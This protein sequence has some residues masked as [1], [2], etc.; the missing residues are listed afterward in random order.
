MLFTP[1][2]LE[3][4][5]YWANKLAGDIEK[6]TIVLGRQQR[7]HAGPGE[8]RESMIINFPGNLCDRLVKLSKGSDLSLY[9]LLMTALKVLIFHCINREDIIVI[10]PVY[11]SR[12]SD[13]TM[14]SCVALRDRV[15]D[16]LTFRELLL[17]V[18][19]ATLQAYE[20][21]DYPFDSL[22]ENVLD[23]TWNNDHISD[24]ACVSSNIHDHETIE[25]LAQKLVFSFTRDAGRLSG[26]IIFEP[27]FYQEIYIEGMAGYFTRILEQAAGDI[28]IKIS[29]ISLLSAQERQQLLVEFNDNRSGYPGNKTILRLF[30]EQVEK[31][32]DHTALVYESQ[33]VTFAE[34][35]KRSD[36]LARHLI[37]KGAA[38]GSITG[39]MVEPCLEMLIGIV[40]ILKAGGIFVPIEPESPKERIS[41]VLKDSGAQVLLTQR[42]LAETLKTDLHTEI[43]I[44]DDRAVYAGETCKL[45]G[46]TQPGDPVYVIYTSGTSGRPKGVLISN[47]N[48]VNYIYWFA[49]SIRL[50]A[51]DRAILTSSFAFD[52]LYTQLFASLLWGCELHIIP[53][54]TFLFAGRLIHYLRDHEITYIKVTPS[55][56]NLI[57]NNPDFSTEMLCR[58]RFIMIGGEEINVKDVEKAH[59]LCPHVRMMNHYGPTETTIGS[60]ARFIDF[61]RFQEYKSVPTIGKPLQ[62]TNVYILDKNFN[63]VP[64]GVSGELFIGGDGVGMGYLNN[65]ELTAGKFVTCSHL[66]EENER[67]YATGDLARWEPDGNIECLGRVDD[68]VK[69]RGYRVEPGEIEN[70][71]LRHGDVK[72][73]LVLPVEKGNGEKYLC[74]YVVAETD[75]DGSQ[76][77]EFLARDLPRYMIPSYFVPLDRMPLTKH[78]KINRQA[79]PVP[80]A[81][82]EGTAGYTAPEDEVEDK[83]A[84]AWAEVLGVKKE[85]IG[86]GLNFFQVGGHSLNAIIL[87]SM[88]HKLFNVEVPLVEL[89]RDPTIKGLAAYIKGASVNRYTAVEPA[90]IKEYYP[91]SSAQK[92][93]YVLQEMDSESTVYNLPLIVWLEGPLNRT[94]F[95]RAFRK[96]IERHDNF[97]TSFNMVDG[98]PIQKI[99]KEVEFGIGYHRLEDEPFT[100]GGAGD[101]RTDKIVRDFVRPFSLEHAPLLR[102]ELVNAAEKK[103]LLMVDMHHIISDGVSN[104][105]LKKEFLQLYA[106]EELSGLRLQYKDFSEWQ[107]NLIECG[108]LEKQK[109]HWLKIFEEEVPVL[110]MPTDYDR[111]ESLSF[112]GSSFNFEIAE[113]LTA[114]TRELALNMGVTLNILLMAV[115]NILLAKYT[116]QEDIVVGTIT[117]GRPHIDL[118]KIIGFFV[119]MLAIRN[120]PREEKTFAEFLEEVKENSIE[121]FENQDYQ[122]EELVMELEAEREP[123]RHPLVETM[124]VL[125]TFDDLPVEAS[126]TGS[127]QMNAYE[128]D[129]KVS[130]LD[131]TLSGIDNH[132]SIRMRIEYSTE[133]FNESTIMEISKFFLD[134]LEQVVENRHIKISEISGT[135]DFLVADAGVLQTGNTEFDF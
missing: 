20:N 123:G 47:R 10:S 88:V 83:L 22:M 8:N 100:E 49:R 73:V 25:N 129:D 50:I 91:L 118:Q 108:L 58:L 79:L 12:I 53:R 31:T 122:F 30:E 5:E 54:E 48:L 37:S 18:R 71:L 19:E 3:Q 7:E 61:D 103:Y 94:Q 121:A 87:V 101:D 60:I 115:Y 109:R 45:T 125:E 126:D 44:L 26:D 24:I 85:S 72:E 102:V 127:L 89:F 29:E 69:I 70:H 130:R 117:A 67:I 59:T 112:G 56:F 35:S 76:L 2:F 23:Q 77:G 4:K 17:Q 120:R 11:N 55:L 15:S 64:I 82:L 107:N 62:N 113:K 42:R 51:A 133:L 46:L 74:A 52:A 116:G 98:E 40:G 33:Q 97:R 9:L 131:L 21:Q 1:R 111:P 93:M 92:R 95:E 110:R 105:I 128:F 14:N 27:G 63:I 134:I 32:P 99:H 119:N 96:L 41:F 68:Q 28:N 66:K 6:T 34:F 124:F 135:H 90:E 39:I 38:P 43:V 104:T 86:T 57:A 114:K 13:E 78:N 75:I 81:L 84:Q 80:G 16:D 132:S 106:G 36:S 65:P